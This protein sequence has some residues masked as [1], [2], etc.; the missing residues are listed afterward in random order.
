MSQL[1]A[2]RV[3]VGA[4]ELRIRELGIF[5]DENSSVHTLSESRKL[6]RC[7]I[8]RAGLPTDTLYRGCEFISKSS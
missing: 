3:E 7:L 4:A 2:L 8:Q 5:D 6:L 1:R